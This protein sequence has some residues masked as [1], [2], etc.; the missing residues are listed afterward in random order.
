MGGSW[1]IARAMAAALPHSPRKG[2]RQPIGVRRQAGGLQQLVGATPRPGDV[3]HPRGEDEVLPQRQ[4]GIEPGFVGDHADQ[5]PRRWIR[6]GLAEPSHLAVAG[7]EQ[8][9]QAAR[10]AWSFPPRWLRSST[11]LC[12]A[13]TSNS[14]ASS[15]IRAPNRLV[16]RRAEMAGGCSVMDALPGGIDGAKGFG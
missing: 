10:A 7:T 15:T 5:P 2:R 9:R 1:R 12:P 3:V 14:I 8:R 4:M 11:T 6:R 13:A 16:R